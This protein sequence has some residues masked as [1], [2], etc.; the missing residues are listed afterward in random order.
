MKLA[1]PAEFAASNPYKVTLRIAII[2]CANNKDLAVNAVT[3]N[4]GSTGIQSAKA[5]AIDGAI[6]NLAGQK[7]NASYK[8]VV[9]QNGKK[10]LQK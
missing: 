6:Y 1:V 7:E 4:F 8:G 2:K 5:A 10:F 9:I 3:F